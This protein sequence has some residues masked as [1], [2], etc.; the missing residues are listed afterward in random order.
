MVYFVADKTPEKPL[1]Q[2]SLSDDRFTRLEG[3]SII[4]NQ[5]DFTI[6][7]MKFYNDELYYFS[8]DEGT[9]TMLNR[10]NFSDGQS[11]FV[12]TASVN[13]R[14]LTIR[15]GIEVVNDKLVVSKFT[16]EFFHEL[17]FLD[18]SV[19]TEDIKDQ[20][21][22]VYPNPTSDRIFVEGL[23]YDQFESGEIYNV[24]G[25]LMSKVSTKE[26]SI[27]ISYLKSGLYKLVLKGN[28]GNYIA[29]F[30]KQDN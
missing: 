6:T 26:K 24:Q 7:K 9:H 28:D 16:E 30:I 1:Y 8:R 25:Q 10:Y 19:S 15:N 5:F 29:S 18:T 27:D 2:L 21:L 11:Y 3:T 17:Y 14:G 13:N 12:D 20:K 22:I 23:K 4:N